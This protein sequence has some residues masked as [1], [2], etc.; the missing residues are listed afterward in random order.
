MHLVFLSSLVPV[1]H[2]ASG[3][4]IAN[5]VVL[6]GLRA[7]GH[8]VTVVGY[9]QPGQTPAPGGDLVL[10]G[11]QEVTN[12]KVG[13]ATKA[14]WLARALL[15]GTTVSSAKMLATSTAK[16][17]AILADLAPFDGLVLNSVQLAG[18]FAGVF[19]RYPFVYVAHNAEAA[20]ARQN[21]STA[22]GRLER[23]LFAREARLLDGLERRL[24]RQ[25][26]AVWTFCEA[27]RHAFGGEV[28]ARAS[29]VPLLRQWQAP[30]REPAHPAYCRDIGLIGT[31]SWAANRTGLD[32]FLNAVVPHLPAD[33]SIEVA[34][35]VP[36]QPV[37]PHRGL[38]FVGRVEDAAQ[39]VRSSRVVPLVS[40]GGTGVQLKTIETFE[41]GMPS[42]ATRSSLRG[43]DA[44]PDNCV[45]ADTPEA[46]AAALVDQVRA[47][48]SGQTGPVSGHDFHERQKAA[49]LAGLSAGLL[50]LSRDPP[51]IRSA[52]APRPSR[53]AAVLSIPDRGLSR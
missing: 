3:F 36:D 44:V 14:A 17:R 24:T 30:P 29:L 34:G 10:L 12:A 39:F 7:L 47:V 2:P 31:W 16:M 32:W 13:R 52:F 43:I 1:D 15:H 9:L 19:A 26:L 6:D 18:A 41:A 21:A 50:A 46:F 4:D 22:G 40:R 25:A 42:V 37:S 11:E 45:M 49:L 23:L 8:R 33:L 5:R 38:R 28:A 51:P 20:T 27:D 48:R 35:S 53:S